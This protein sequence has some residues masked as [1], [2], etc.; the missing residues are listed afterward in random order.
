MLELYTFAPST[1]S[2]KVRLLLAEK[3]LDFEEH[4]LNSAKNEHLSEEYLKLNPNGV[5]PTLV[6]DGN[7][8]I[9]SAVILEYLEEVF[10]EPPK[11]PRDAVGR[12]KM[13]AWI[14]FFEEF[15]VPAVRYPTFQ[16]YLRHNFKDKDKNEQI[17]KRP[18]K[19]DFY[20]RM[21]REDGFTD[22]EME[23]AFADIRLTVTRM[24][25]ALAKGGPYLMGKEWT[26]A[27]ACVTPAIDRMNDL[28]HSHLWEDLPHVKAWIEAIRARP[29]F[30]KAYYPGARMS[31]I[32]EK[33]AGAAAE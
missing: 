10:P 25:E 23:K 5:V 3:G 11:A 27:D 33:K 30:D 29:S 17:Q 21:L 32:Y 6:H 13:R 22:T 16:K 24:E 28:G 7:V 15:A 26:L 19:S 12:A 4:V 8:I 18:L 9:E 2:Q 14:H 20:T 31:E 1:C